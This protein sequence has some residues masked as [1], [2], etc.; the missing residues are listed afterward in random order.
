[1]KKLT[2]HKQKRVDRSVW[3]P[4]VLCLALAAVLVL[5]YD[6]YY[7]LNDDFL[8]EH[9][10]S[11]KYTGTP[12]LYNIQSLF[13]LTTLLGGLYRLA[14]GVAW[15]GIF[16]LACQ[17]GALCVSLRRILKRT[18]SVLLTILGALTCAGMLWYH[19]VFVQYSVTVGMLCAAAAVYLMT[20]REDEI[21]EV[22][23]YLL[24]GA[25]L[26]LSFNLRSE[27]TL[28]MLPFVLLGF[29]GRIWMRRASVKR[30]VRAIGI[31]GAVLLLVILV[32][33]AADRIGYRSADWKE[34]R[35]FFDARTQLYDFQTI[36]DFA[37]NRE[38]YEAEGITR[39]QVTLLQN[40]NFGLDDTIDSAFM[41]KV[42]AYA[43][44]SRGV[45]RPVKERIKGALWSYQR[46]PM[47]KTERPWSFVVAVL[48]GMAVLDAIRRI[49]QGRMAKQKDAGRIFGVQ[50]MQIALI[51]FVRSGLWLYL[52]YHERPVVRLTHCIYLM[53]AVLLLGVIFAGSDPKSGEEEAALKGSEE[54]TVT[55]SEPEEADGAITAA[56]KHPSDSLQQAL[57]LADRI[58][59]GM[60]GVALAL[61]LCIA[62]GM[63][64]RATDAEF[65]RRA[66]VNVPYQAFLEYCDSHRDETFFADVFSTVDFS[67]KMFDNKGYF[68]NWDFMGGWACKSPLYDKKL[69]EGGLKDMQSGLLSEGVY[70]VDR[71]DYDTAWL[72]DYYAARGIDVTV[73][74]TGEIG[75]YWSIYKVSDIK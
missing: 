38:F 71:S 49:V 14:G 11:G 27:M 34:F 39:E 40:Y 44:A 23:S 10:L 37:E 67:E 51:Y 4:P 3:L 25:V 15:Y 59:R 16:L 33:T 66:A 13:P 75:A 52:L 5:R 46:L 72:A 9:L 70:L 48:Y 1:M 54:S 45:D 17:F 29:W 57:Q 28:F 35:A 55:A 74:K 18:G 53:E 36:P 6:F 69:A 41:E 73:T 21:T 30:G 26:L 42:A 24:P 20:L 12:E 2:D 31:L 62:T 22:K 65:D 19:L 43:K 50:L 63:Q 68:T 58:S 32:S 64:I 61:V 56:T 7:D 8:M 47:E 60:I